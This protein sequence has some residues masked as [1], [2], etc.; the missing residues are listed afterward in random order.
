[1][2]I[3]KMRLIVTEAYDNP[4]WHLK[5]RAMPDNQVQAI[6]F[7]LLKRGSLNKK[8]STKKNPWRQLSLFDKEGVNYGINDNRSL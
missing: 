4:T 2:D 8:K 5:V 1:M 7:S 6:Y 3:A